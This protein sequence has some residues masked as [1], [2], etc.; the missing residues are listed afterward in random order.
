MSFFIIFI[1]LLLSAFFSG[2]ETSFFSMDI[3]QRKKVEKKR[4]KNK[5]Y[6]RI[7]RLLEKPKELLIIILLGNTIVNV[8]ASATAT[9]IAINLFPN[10]HVLVL[11]F[12]IIIMTSVILIFGEIIPKLI[13]I[14][15]PE[16]FA[17]A[18]SIFLVI[19]KIVLF[20]IV[21]LL[22][23]ISNLFSK[24]EESIEEV[25]PQDIK[26]MLTLLGDD[27]D[28]ETNKI[29]VRM[30]RY[31]KTT[32]EEIMQ[33]RV[34]IVAVDEDDSMEELKK[35]IVASGHSKI[36]VYKENVDKITGYVHAK[37]L[38]LNPNANIQKLKREPLIIPENQPISK[39]LKLFKKKKVHIAIVWWMNTV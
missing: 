36:P 24:G 28:P 35:V 17:G 1:L 9:V 26:Y 27:L 5:T 13:A 30:F 25:T 18:A 23:F 32:V 39:L 22:E 21:K 15:H 20:P 2:S 38:I 14:S 29:L 3:I 11:L 4:S 16:Q 34:D 33:P 19:M 8:A 37:D 12:E 31:N 10:S 7:S 6:R